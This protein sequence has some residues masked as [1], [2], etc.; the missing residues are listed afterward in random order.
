MTPVAQGRRSLLAAAVLALA[1]S[2]PVRAN[3]ASLVQ[4]TGFGTNPTNLEMYLYVPDNVA[5][6]PGLLLALHYCTGTGPAFFSGSEFRS[7]ADRYGFI[8]IYPSATR[9]G[10]CWDVSSPQALKR[11]GGSDPVGLRSMISYVQS[12]YSV[13]ASKIFVT[14][15]SSGGMMTNVMLGDYPDVFK[16]GAAYMGVPFGC[17]ATTDGSSWN[18]QCSG[19]TLIKTAQQWGDLV[20]AAYPGYSGARPRMQVLHGTT[21]T[22]LNYANYGEE[23]KQWT[24]VLGVS[25]TATETGTAGSCNRSRYGGTGVQPPVEGISCPGVGHSLPLSGQ[26]ALSIA[27]FGLDQTSQGTNYTLTVTKS[28]TGTGTVAGG[29]I[30]CGST[31]SASIASGTAVTLTA[32]PASGSTF[33]GWSGACTGTGSCIVT[34]TAAQSV[35]ASFTTGTGTTFALTV[36]KSGTGSGTV[37]GGPINC[38]TT[39]SANVASG[40]AVT[41]TATPASGSTFGGWSGACTGTG[42][43]IA[44]MTAARSVTA[45]FTGTVTTGTVSINAGGSATGSWIADQYFSG[46]STYTTT[47]TIDTSLLTGTVPPQAVFQ[48]E[49]YGEFTYTITGRSGAQ[50]VTLYFQESYWTAAGQRTFNVSINGTAALTAFDIFAAAGGANRAIARTFNTTANASGQVVIQFTRN[51]ADQP[52]ICGITLE[53]G[54]G[55]TNQTLTVTKAGTGSG[56]VSGSGIN[57]GTTCTA[58]IATG[59]SA[60]LTATPASG[61]TFAGW[62]GACSG[63]ASCVVAMTAAQSVGATFN[64]SGGT[65]FALTVTKSGTGSGTVTASAAGIDCGTVCSANVASG[66]AVTLAATPAT[67]STFAGW[68]GACSGTGACVVTMTAAQTVGAAFNTSGGGTTPCA[69][70]VTFTTNTGNFNSTGAVCYRTS[71]TVNGWGCS[72][73]TGRTVSVNGGTAAATCGG[74]PLP[75]AKVD[76]YTYFSAS[77]G[78]YAWA[79]IYIW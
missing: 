25:Q 47:N 8:A 75:L 63:T 17:F 79:S 12:R 74:G 20:R 34:M 5:A 71:N 11:D 22:T 33:G 18:S 42:S 54:G 78:T 72:N 16:A 62:S 32:T 58:S 38:G 67:G 56:A 2:A 50:T 15:A 19:G 41:L 64:T 55:T 59:T 36:T 48:T 52:K 35:G 21:D 51:G 57:C 53:A 23:I 37:A 9:S 13:D 39:C 77:A 66:T 27:F 69:N 70:P 14:G 49:R 44:T 6:R 68:S 61:S 3:A 28:G 43:C 26:A 1:L 46:G 7:L 45:T 24:N 10:Q 31:C 73:F 30:N 65:S 76:G 40:T 29:A 4:V 60:T